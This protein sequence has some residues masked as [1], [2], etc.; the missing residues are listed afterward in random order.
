MLLAALLTGPALGPARGGEERPSGLRH[1]EVL[2]YAGAVATFSRQRATAKPGSRPWAEATLGLAVARQCRQPDT[3]AD[4]LAAEALCRELVTRLQRTPEEPAYGP[5]L[6]VLGQMAAAV[7]Y[8]GDRTDVAAARAW[9]QRLASEVHHDELLVNLAVLNLA[10]LDLQTMTPAKAR[11]GIAALEAWLAAHPANP[12]ASSQWLAVGLAYA[13]PLGNLERATAAFVKADA[14]G[15]PN[16]SAVP[17][18][19]RR[20][21]CQALAS[22]DRAMAAR[23]F[24]RLATELGQTRFGYEAELALPGLD[25]S[26]TPAPGAATR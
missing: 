2:D 11:A 6:F 22:G 9:Y 16:R 17:V 5:A 23:Y 20:I 4:K 13:Y 18:L 19:C 12:L 15:L 25:S 10:I 21:A 26:P 8:P 3:R 1:L 7:D 14:A 24:R